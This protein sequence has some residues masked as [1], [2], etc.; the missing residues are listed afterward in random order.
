[1]LLP[2]TLTAWLC[3]SQLYAPAQLQLGSL[4]ASTNPAPHSFAS[5]P[6]ADSYGTASSF[7]PLLP[8]A[9]PLAVKSPYVNAW[10]P[11]GGEH[12]SG[13]YLV[14][15]W[16]KHWPISYPPTDKQYE[17]GWAGLIRIDDETFEFLGDPL[18]DDIGTKLIAN[19]TGFG[20]TAT[21]SIF[22]FEARGV[23]FK[24]IFLSPV[25]PHDYV[26]A[27]L[28][29]SFL[30]V[31]VDPKVLKKHRISVYSDINGGWATGDANADL[32]WDYT[33]HA[34][35]GIHEISR[36]KELRFAEVDQQAEWGRAVYATKIAHGVVAG[37]G[38]ASTLRSHFVKKGHLDGSQDVKYRSTKDREPVFAYS[39]QLSEN[40]PSAVFTIG[41]M[42][43]PYVNYVTPDGQVDRNGY[44]TTRF[45]GPHDAIS[46]W[47]GDYDH[48]IKDAVAF[49]KKL[50]KDAIAVSGENYAAIVE[51]STRQAFATFEIT[52]GEKKDDVMAFLKEISSNGD[53]G[54]V[55]V[56]F[57]L[58][59]ILQ[60]TNP[61]L[62][63]LLLEPIMTYTASGLYP[64]RWTVHDLGTYPNA[65]GYNEGNDEPMPVE[66]AGNMLWM[67]LAYW[68]MSKD[69]AWVEKYYDILTQWTTYLIEDGLIPAEQLSTDDFAGTL[70][71][72]TNLAVKAIV[73]IGAMG[74]LAKATGRWTQ[75]IHYEGTAK[76]YVQEWYQLALTAHDYKHPH[77]KLAYQDEGSS[78]L[79]YNLF[80][81]R[82]LNLEL[83]DR[84][85]Y[86]WQSAWY[87]TR[88]EEYG[89]PL[90]TRHKWTKSDW[91]VFTA[92]SAT[93]V[94]TRDLFIDLLV[95]YLKA[96][97]V[98]AGFPDLYETNNAKF[99]GRDGQDW[100]IE[101]I[102]RPVV[103]GHFALLALDVANKANGVRR[104][105]FKEGGRGKD[106]AGGDP[107]ERLGFV[108]QSGGGSSGVSWGREY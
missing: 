101:F 107:R 31:E 77:A 84:Q 108:D 106:L 56:I 59:P 93:D 5:S 50:R 46:F 44:W 78:G 83:F 89:I 9:I 92:A 12:G 82:I 45:H 65:T 23:A 6:V 105:P 97:K 72:Q 85:L 81:D 19:Q 100:N 35:A 13:G 64:N 69:T 53:M 32:T 104:D 48:A 94:K 16:T 41:H 99:P 3:S 57:P 11:A 40:S 60:Y 90:D 20:Y 24:V 96:G 14:G 79:L 68:Q 70:S 34:G 2:S 76:A 67:I 87:H 18:R 55:D 10:L 95:K 103:G 22:S 1:M 75:Y 98:D 38:K 63:K 52:V 62:I 36:A 30:S 74:Q 7:T 17:L 4:C 25:T 102:S 27:S 58:Y 8:P 39:V 73:G 47:V 33:V 54:T 49:D 91:E 29:L 21:Q 86:E 42:R 37:S 15:S 88:K 28:P 80:G 51:L 66:E 71:N 61:H 43:F 26:R